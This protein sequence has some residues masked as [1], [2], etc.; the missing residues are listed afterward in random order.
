ML[1]SMMRELW[2]DVQLAK[3]LRSFH[4]MRDAVYKEECY[5]MMT[6]CIFEKH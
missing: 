6:R 4:L 3:T 5:G 1:F 2:D